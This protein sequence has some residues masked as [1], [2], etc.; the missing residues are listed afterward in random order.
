MIY[1]DQVAEIQKEKGN[2]AVE[3]MLWELGQ[4]LPNFIR[5]EDIP[6]RYDGEVLCVILPGADK[7]ITLDRAERIRREI[8]QLQ[9]A[10]GDG[11]LATNL[12]LGVSVM[13][14]HAIDE[15]TLIYNGQRALQLAMDNGGNRVVSADAL[16]QY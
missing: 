5:T 12:S 15:G 6:C 14:D 11:I 10:Y 16:R 4:R 1:P 13:P 7:K 9:V 8:S 3:Q 2:H